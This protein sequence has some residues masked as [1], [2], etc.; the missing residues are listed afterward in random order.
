MTYLT[1]FSTYVNGEEHIFHKWIKPDKNYNHLN[2][3]QENMSVHSTILQKVDDEQL[4]G[5][6]FVFQYNVDVMLE[7][8]KLMVLKLL[9]TLSYQKK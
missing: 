1:K 2:Q 8:M 5:S 3:D 4:E 7:F 6:G 9:Y